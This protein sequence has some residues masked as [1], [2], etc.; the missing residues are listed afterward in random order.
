MKT[1]KSE[2][3]DASGAVSKITDKFKNRRLRVKKLKSES[4]DAS[5]AVSKKREKKCR[6]EILPGFPKSFFGVHV[7][8]VWW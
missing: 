1:T 3:K 4:K 2:S 7:A 5:G 8:S 6:I